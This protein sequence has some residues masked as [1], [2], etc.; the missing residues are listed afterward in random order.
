MNKIR[1]HFSIISMSLLLLTSSGAFAADASAG[2]VAATQ[3]AMCHGVNGEGNG[4]PGSSIAG[5]DADLFIKHLRDFKS[6]TRRNV[7][8]ERF[9]NRLSDQ[10]IENLAAYF[11]PK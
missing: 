2:R 9:A 6:G 5:M 10:D 3:C 7:M 8:M 4:I 11:A 1:V